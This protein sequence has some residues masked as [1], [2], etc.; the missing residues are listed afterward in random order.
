M[1]AKLPSADPEA[2]APVAASGAVAGSGSS[3]NLVFRGAVATLV[4]RMALHGVRLGSNIALTQLLLPEHFGVMA[5][6]NVTMLGL[7][8]FSDLGIATAVIQSKHGDEARYLGTAFTLQVIRGVLLS[9]VACLIAWPMA[10]VYED[11]PDLVWAV[12]LAGMT[13]LVDGFASTKILTESR[14]MRLGRLMVMDI[15]AAVT[16]ALAMV[17]TAWCGGALMSLVVG[18][19]AGGIVRVV[20]SHRW[21]PGLPDRFQWDGDARRKLFG[22]SVWIFVSTAMTFV[23]MQVD[24]LLLGRLVDNATLGVYSIA[25]MMAALP[26]E[27]V[28]QLLDRVLYPW[29]AKSLREQCDGKSVL[30]ARRRVLLLSVVPIAMVSAQA[31]AIFRVL[32]PPEYQGGG[33]LMRMLSVG[34]WTSIVA[35]SYGIVVLAR[36]VPRFITYATGLK[37]VTCIA[38]VIPV[39]SAFGIQGVATLVVLSEVMVAVVAGLGCRGLGVISVVTDVGCTLALL[40]IAWVVHVGQAWSANE[41][42]NDWYGLVGFGSLGLVATGLIAWSLAGAW[43]RRVT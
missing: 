42:G 8:M 41:L 22:F 1:T 34:A 7:Q 28:T 38:L 3:R 40:A 26:R 37:A 29:V 14:H 27:I 13:A 18:G 23:S 39:H 30:M 36:G 31:D 25:V 32:F 10:F 4:G 6:V 9:I 20:M 43:R 5:I 17:L 2:S 12:P 24:R 11:M 16:S 33:P 21:L 35:G 15:V 19:I